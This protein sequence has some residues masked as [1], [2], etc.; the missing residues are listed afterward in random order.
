MVKG[1]VEQR[2]QTSIIKYIKSIGG[3]PIK[4]NQIG[5]YAQAGVPDIIA[6]IKGRF[7]A[8]EVKRPGQKPTPIQEAFLA[9]IAKKG[10]VAFWAD[11]LDKVKNELKKENLN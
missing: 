11:N 9:S 5:I 3:L 10:G 6:C 2:I 7:V 8:I 1:S 4:Q